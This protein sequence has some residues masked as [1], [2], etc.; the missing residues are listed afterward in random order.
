MFINRCFLEHLSPESSLLNDVHPA[1]SSKNLPLMN[2]LPTPACD[3]RFDAVG[4]AGSAGVGAR[5]GQRRARTRRLRASAD[6]NLAPVPD[7]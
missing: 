6:M 7:P 4:D 2:T 5:E 1:I 3:D